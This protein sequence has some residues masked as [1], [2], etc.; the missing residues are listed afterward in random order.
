MVTSSSPDCK[1]QNLI[2]LSARDTEISACFLALPPPAVLCSHDEHELENSLSGEHVG[3][4]AFTL[5][6][7]STAGKSFTREAATFAFSSKYLN[8]ACLMF[9]C[10]LHML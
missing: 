3:C 10:F 7:L 8:H 6:N 1:H 4:T 5:V 2:H 9:T